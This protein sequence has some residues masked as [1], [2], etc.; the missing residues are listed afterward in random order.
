MINNSPCKSG[1]GAIK[2]ER[3]WRRQY[4]NHTEAIRGVT[5]Y[6]VNFYNNRRL[7]SSLGYLL[8]NSMS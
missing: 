3:V 6:I 1:D 4:A 7:Q 5:D 8:P 2:M